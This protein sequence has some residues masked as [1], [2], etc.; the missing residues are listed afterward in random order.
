MATATAPGK[1]RCVVCAKEKATSKCS[2]C[3]QDYCFNHLSEHRQELARQLDEIEV[4]RDL[5]Q[6]TIL[7]EISDREKHVV[8]QEI[9]QWE[10]NSIEKI[11]QIAQEARETALKHT[12]ASFDKTKIKLNQLTNEIKLARKEDDL[13]EIDLEKWTKQLKQLTEELNK[14]IDVVIRQSSTSIVSRI[15]VDVE[16]NSKCYI[17]NDSKWNQ[18]GLTIAGGNGRGTELN[19]LSS[20]FGMRIDDEETLY[21]A[22]QSNNRIIKWQKNATHGLIAAGGNGA[23]D[24]DNQLY[25]PKHVII[26]DKTDSLII[27]D[28]GNRRVVRWSR[29]NPIRG[30]TIISNISCWGLAMDNAGYLYATDTEKHEVRRWKI[31]EETGKL[32]AG[33]HGKGSDLDQFYEP[34]YIYVD[35]EQ[36]V[37]VSDCWNNRIMKWKKGAQKGIVVAGGHGR[38]SARNQLYYPHAFVVDQCE[39][40]YIADFANHRVIRWLKGAHE[41]SII[42]GNGNE[43]NQS[44]QFSFVSDLT[45]DRQNNLYVVDLNNFRIQKFLINELK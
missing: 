40:L 3:S 12:D 4:N 42:A 19:Q 32:V 20:A 5:F 34:R 44:N 16:V 39:T 35:D 22:D 18:N 28:H 21:I 10:K 1:S 15:I 14:P 37:Y 13:T 31:G 6:Q 36:S 45:F 27:A 43:G 17:P 30:E 7:Q 25:L 26:D 41:S 8:L 23:G 11:Q 33:G 24:Q 2:G 29:Q 9:D 38:G